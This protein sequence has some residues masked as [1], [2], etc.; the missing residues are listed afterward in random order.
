[1]T[2]GRHS[3]YTAEI[4][5]RILDQLSS[6]RSLTAIC[7]DPG[8]PPS[9]TVWQW[10]KDDREGFAAR[11]CQVRKIAG[12]KGGGPTV[13]TAELAGKILEGLSEG[14][15]L[16]EVCR[17]PGM[18]T[19]STV[20]NW[21]DDNREGFAARYTEARLMGYDAM[22]DEIITIADD[23]RGDWTPR[24]RKDGTT[25]HVL[26]RANISHARLRIAARKWLL[27]KALPKNYGDRPNLLTR[28]QARD[29]LAKAS[30]EIEER[31]RA[32][33]TTGVG[34]KAADDE[35]RCGATHAA[36]S[37]PP[38]RG[39]DSSGA[40]ISGVGVRESLSYPPP[41][42]PSPARGVGEE[43]LASYAASCDAS[44]LSEHAPAS[45]LKHASNAASTI[46]SL[47]ACAA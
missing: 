38:L 34:K 7:G 18:P 46:A 1:M 4:A 17:E 36:C 19:P 47:T 25:D 23:S 45:C 20:R 43:A 44:P 6:G 9:R 28:L 32:A 26:N 39:G 2:A 5:Q 27:S 29:A 33:D 10:L 24:R 41:P 3:H 13:Y 22:K 11:F 42:Q 21:A 37:P 8:M 35:K 31:N 16:A 30:K 12:A 15:T 14:Q 40:R